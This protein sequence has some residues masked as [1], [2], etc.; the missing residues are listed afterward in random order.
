MLDYTKDSKDNICAVLL[1]RP[2]LSLDYVTFA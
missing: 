2:L 1:L